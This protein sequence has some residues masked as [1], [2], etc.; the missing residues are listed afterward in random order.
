MDG[1]DELDAHVAKRAGEPFGDVAHVG[2]EQ[3]EQP[4]AEVGDGLAVIHVAGGQPD[5]Q[6]FALRVNDGMQL[7]TCG[8][9]RQS[10]RKFRS[11]GLWMPLNRWLTLAILQLFRRIRAFSIAT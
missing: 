4:L 2:E 10:G 3:A 5:A 9:N 7:R 8:K 11:R 6:Q 1:G